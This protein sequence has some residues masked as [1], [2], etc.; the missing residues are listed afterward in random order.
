MDPEEFEPHAALES[1]K[2]AAREAGQ[3]LLEM[4]GYVKAREKGRADLVTEADVASQAKIQ[5]RLAADFPK[6]HFVGE[7]SDPSEHVQ[8]TNNELYWIVDPLDGTTNYVHGMDNYSVSIAL[9]RG[10][11]T[12]L[13]AIYDPNR[14]LMFAAIDGVGAWKNHGPLAVSSTERVEDA[15][16][17]A[18][19][20]AHVPRD[21]PEIGRFLAVLPHAQAIR[22]MGSA[23]LNLCYVSTGQLDAYWATSLKLWDAAAGLLIVKEA[24]GHVLAIDG[25]A[26]QLSDPRFVV[27]ATAPLAQRLVG[28]LSEAGE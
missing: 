7:E 19:F 6:I 12:L 25:T 3:L 15:L 22:R 9:C 16:V 13:G 28:L 5:S 17:A 18:S 10:G 27:A 4:Q 26:F 21:S 14:D 20:S 2:T 8:P 23:A 1:V 24:G 11:E